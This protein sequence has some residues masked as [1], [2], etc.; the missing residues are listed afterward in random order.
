M[1]RTVLVVLAAAAFAACEQS[2]PA[3]PTKTVSSLSMSPGTDWIKIKAAEKFTVTAL[4]S[5]GAAEVVTPAWSSD[6]ATVATVDAAGTVT[7]V[8]AGLATIAAA[9]QGQSATRTLRVIPDYAGRWAGNWAVTSCAVQGD[10]IANWCAPVNNGSFPATLDILQTKDVVSATWVFQEATGNHP[11][12]IATAG[13]LSLT[14]SSFQSGVR[15]EIASWQTVTSD[16]R[17][18]T[19][20]FTLRWT[21]DGRSGSA[22]TVIDLRNFTKQ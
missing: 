13:P 6:A 17:A 9:F 16:N 19:G 5:T 21:T 20:T 10:F 12:S 15:I 14:G 1:R 11:G 8:A 7:G 4:Y 3:E 18:M 22:Q 2:S